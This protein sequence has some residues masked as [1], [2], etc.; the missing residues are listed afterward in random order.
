MDQKSNT[1]NGHLT[2]T[3]PSQIKQSP[4]S[5]TVLHYFNSTAQYCVRSTDIIYYYLYWIHECNALLLLRYFSRENRFYVMIP[6][7]SRRLYDKTIPWAF[8]ERWTFSDIPQFLVGAWQKPLDRGS[9]MWDNYS[10]DQVH[11]HE[12]VFEYYAESWVLIFVMW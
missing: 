6:A 2:P 9:A 5:N 10:F 1:W 11:L 4:S 7:Y 8:F 12:D 3:H